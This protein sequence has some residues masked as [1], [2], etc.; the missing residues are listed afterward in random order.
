ME[1]KNISVKSVNTP[2]QSSKNTKSVKAGELK[3][4]GMIKDKI[5][6][7]NEA[8][9]LHNKENSE[10]DLEAIRQRVNSNYYNNSDVIKTVARSIIKDL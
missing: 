6:I 9:E 1:V 2:V 3:F 7:S 5:E 4:E 10:A 8:K